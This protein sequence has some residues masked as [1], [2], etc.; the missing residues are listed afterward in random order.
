MNVMKKCI[1]FSQCISGVWCTLITREIFDYM[2]NFTDKEIIEVLKSF[3]DFDQ[4]T[5]DGVD[6]VLNECVIVYFNK[7]NGP[8]RLEII[9]VDVDI[10]NLISL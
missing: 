5:V 4:F 9:L 2:K 10:D 3:Q 1:R 7:S 6:V 8:I